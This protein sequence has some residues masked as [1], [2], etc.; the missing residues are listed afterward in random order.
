MNGGRHSDD[1]LTAPDGCGED[2]VS[3]CTQP[4]SRQRWFTSGGVG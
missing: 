2:P 3:A 1:A 4:M